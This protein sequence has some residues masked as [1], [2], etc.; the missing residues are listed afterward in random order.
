MVE[1]D[2]AEWDRE[3]EADFR[4][5]VAATRAA[6][7][8]KKAEPFAIVPLDWATKAAKAGKSPATIICIRLLYLSWKTKSRTVILSNRDGINRGSKDRVLRNLE[9]AKLIQVDRRSGRSPRV[10]ILHPLPWC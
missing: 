2:L 5:A 3:I 1:R 8:R 7:K 9:R 6:G 10:T 4:R